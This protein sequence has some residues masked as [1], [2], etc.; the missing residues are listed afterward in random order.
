MMQRHLLARA[1][2]EALGTGMLV[3]LGCAIGNTDRYIAPIDGVGMAALWGTVVAVC[4]YTT[5]DISGAH[6]NPAVT[7]AFCATGKHPWAELPAFVAAQLLG[8][9]VRGGTGC[10][11][12]A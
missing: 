2:A 9:T 10:S 3:Q 7:L 12:A 4:A 11:H 6:L 8:A 5:R 1:A